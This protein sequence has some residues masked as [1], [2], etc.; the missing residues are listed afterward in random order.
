[1]SQADLITR[2][3]SAVA[4]IVAIAS[5]L[6]TRQVD[7][8]NLFVDMHSRLLDPDLVKARR[9]LYHFNSV[10]DV[11]SFNASEP[12]RMTHI[13]RLLAMYDLLGLYAEKR[14]V[15]RATVLAEW[16][17][18]LRRSIPHARHVLDWRADWT[19]WDNWPHYQDLAKR[20]ARA[21]DGG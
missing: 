19:G 21:V 15:K 8:R 6:R 2:A 9:D 11:A 5:F 14:W 1:M 4:L 12:E 16:R 13:Y 20:A 10:D 7:R 18:S 17:H 3:V